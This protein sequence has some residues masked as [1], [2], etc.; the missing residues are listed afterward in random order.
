MRRASAR[1]DIV[2][3]YNTKG[4]GGGAFQKAKKR[5][6]MLKPNISENRY[7]SIVWIWGFAPSP[8][9]RAFRAFTAPV[10]RIALWKPSGGNT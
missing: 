5:A 9:Q 10:W 8:H 7:L 3:R 4:V 2:G 6:V 1:L